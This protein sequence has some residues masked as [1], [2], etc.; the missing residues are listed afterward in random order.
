MAYLCPIL[1]A[2]TGTASASLQPAVSA[3][4]GRQTIAVAYCYLKRDR[5]AVRQ[6][7]CF[8]TFSASSHNAAGPCIGLVSAARSFKASK[9][10]FR[11]LRE[12]DSL[13]KPI[14][15]RVPCSARLSSQ[16][17]DFFES[18][19]HRTTELQARHLQGLGVQMLYKHVSVVDKKDTSSLANMTLTQDHERLLEPWNELSF[20]VHAE[21]SGG[22]ADA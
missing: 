18:V 20:V 11:S 6:H 21:Q 9:L 4:L 22:H 8:Y 2:E 10:R 14:L 7:D 3:T 12:A 17:Y 19:S 15:H 13:E 1:L 5:A 16:A